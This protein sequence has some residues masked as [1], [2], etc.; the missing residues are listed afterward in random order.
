MVVC[1]YQHRHGHEH[2][3][4][5][6]FR[7]S[8]KLDNRRHFGRRRCFEPGVRGP[9]SISPLVPEMNQAQN[10]LNR[11]GREDAKILALYGFRTA[12]ACAGKTAWPGISIPT[13]MLCA[14]CWRPW[15][16][17]AGGS[18]CLQA[19]VATVAAAGVTRRVR[20]CTS[21][22]IQLVLRQP[23]IDGYRRLSLMRASAVE[24]R[25]TPSTAAAFRSLCQ[26]ATSWRRAGGS[27]MRRFKPWRCKIP[28]PISAM[29]NQQPCLGE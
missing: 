8:R 3:V 15:S 14:A 17:R 12:L 6:K 4:H 28:N 10:F 19:P 1:S 2:L 22:L 16:T 29:F 13:P 7:A 25:Q 11:T 27:R 20:S 23:L 26:A 24:N 5:Q 9:T 21:C 18:S